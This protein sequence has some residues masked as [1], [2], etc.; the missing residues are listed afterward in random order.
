MRMEWCLSEETTAANESDMKHLETPL[1]KAKLPRKALVYTDKGYDSME[2]K[3]NPQT[4][5]T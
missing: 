3:R 1:K 5:E 4:Y 2:N